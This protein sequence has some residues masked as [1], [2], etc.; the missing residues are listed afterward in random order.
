MNGK[1]LEQRIGE[2]TRD[3]AELRE[4]HG[5]HRQ[6]NTIIYSVLI[7]IGIALSA[8]AAMYGFYGTNPSYIPSIMAILV[9]VSISLESAFKF[10]EKEA[11]YRI[12]VGECDNLMIAL[13]YRVDNEQ[14]LQTMVK[15]YQVVV[16]ISARSIPRGEGMQSVKTM[17]E[18]L[19]RQGIIP[20][21]ELEDRRQ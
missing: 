18:D 7:L 5:K 2:L 11:F 12:L 9:G 10:G 13:K 1:D 16:D 14:K 15:K 21:P 8:T 20:V 4:K 17:Y 19:D 6:R 3:I